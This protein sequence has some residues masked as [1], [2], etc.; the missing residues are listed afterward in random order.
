MRWDAV[1]RV[2]LG[3]LVALALVAGTTVAP[4]A[5]VARAQTGEGEID[6]CAEN[7]DFC[8]CFFNDCYDPD[9]DYVPER[10]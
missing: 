6:P 9:P 7:P 2:L 8:W 4:P 1:R 5:G 10:D 3:G